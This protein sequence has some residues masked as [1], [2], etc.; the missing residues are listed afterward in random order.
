MSIQGALNMIGQ[1]LSELREQKKCTQKDVSNALNISR[2]AYGF[3]EADKRSPDYE[4]LSKLADFFGVSVSY[5]LGETTSQESNLATGEHK[6]Y[7]D[8]IKGYDTLNEEDQRKVEEYIELL[9]L[10]YKE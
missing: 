10:K 8:R 2:Q 7:H 6:L 5:L 3:Y 1:R 9:N 4:T